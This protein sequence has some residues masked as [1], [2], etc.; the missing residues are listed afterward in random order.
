MKS[1]IFDQ[2]YSKSF[3]PKTGGSGVIQI[4]REPGGRDSQMTRN[5]FYPPRRLFLHFLIWQVR[6]GG[7]GAAAAAFGGAL[8]TNFCRARVFT[9]VFV[10][11]AFFGSSEHSS[12]APAFPTLLL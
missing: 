6:L 12:A 8:L 3:V 1:Q 2:S 9:S 5:P 11:D 10:R 7:G 4:C